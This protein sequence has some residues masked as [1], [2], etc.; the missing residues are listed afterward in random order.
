[1]NKTIEGNIEYKIDLIRSELHDATK[2]F[3][4]FNSG[5]EGYAVIKE[6]VEEM[7]EAIKNKNLDEAYKEA[8]QVGAMALRFLIDIKKMKAK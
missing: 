6:E 2:K 3:G 5:H 8:I 4:S 1:M 7:W